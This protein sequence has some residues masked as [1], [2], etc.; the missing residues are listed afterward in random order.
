M[1]LGVGT[2]KQK[3][4]AT[5]AHFF[6]KVLAEKEK[7]VRVYTQN[8]DGLDYQVGLE[9]DLIVPLHGSI[10]KAS[11]EFCK[12]EY[13][14]PEFCDA[15]QTKIKNIYDEMDDPE[16]PSES[17]SILCK[18][19]Q[20]PG[21]KASTVLYGANLPTDAF[22]KMA[23]DFPDRVDLLIIIG[24]SLTVYPAAGLVE[25]VNKSVPR[26]L[27]NVDP[28]G[29]ELGLDYVDEND[30]AFGNNSYDNNIVSSDE[31]YSTCLSFPQALSSTSTQVTRDAWMQGNS[32][33]SILRLA[34]A[35]DYLEDLSKYR[36]AMCEN[37]V[38]LLDVALSKTKEL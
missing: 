7:L 5:L 3:W 1:D 27:V 36:D 9:N 20:R 8:I 37:S 6:L 31:L 24:T 2:A 23:I 21:V 13:P 4:K 38:N 29:R 33:E 30:I 15:V 17:S 26:L 32:D 18:T 22:E 11:C 19:C 25:Q 28:V 35:L 34:I 14:F 12:E 16:A 10:G